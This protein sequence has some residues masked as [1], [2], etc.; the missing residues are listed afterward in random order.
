MRMIKP[1]RVADDTYRLAQS[2]IHLKYIGENMDRITAYVRAATGNS[3]V[4]FSLFEVSEDSPLAWNERELLRHIIEK[5]PEVE[6][7]ISGLGLKLM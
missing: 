6:K 1:E 4:A 3:R 7:F 2:N 5:S